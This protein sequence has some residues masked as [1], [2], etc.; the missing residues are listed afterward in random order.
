M[1]TRPD[2]AYAVGMLCRAMGKPTPDLYLDALRV[3]YYLHQHRD[4]GLRYG[5]SDL[6]LS[7]MSDSDWAV[8]HS[9]TGY[10]FTY[11]LAAVSWGE[12]EASQR[13]VV[14]VRSGDRRSQRGGEV[15][16]LSLRVSRR[17]RIRW[18]FAAPARDRQLGCAR[19]L[20]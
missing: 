14:L 1:N 13:R 4:I 15:R 7:G 12:Q 18:A 9:T 8:R 3:L 17:A 6:D 20:V 2:V 5:A 10:V 16:R 19:P 11:G